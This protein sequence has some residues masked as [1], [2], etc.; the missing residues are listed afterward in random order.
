MPISNVRPEA[1]TLERLATPIGTAI[2]VTDETGH[3]RAFNWTDYEAE[4]LAWLDRHY[5][6][7]SLREGKTAEAVGGRL[8][9]YFNGEAKALDTVPWQASGTPFQLKVWNALCTIPVGETLSYA[10][11]AQRIGRPTAD[12]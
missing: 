4:M 2:V 3:L 6:R 1:L 9:A 10:A 12:G 11:L 7:V 8:L 5:P